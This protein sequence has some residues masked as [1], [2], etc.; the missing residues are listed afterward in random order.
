MPELTNSHKPMT[1]PIRCSFC[2][3]IP[4]Q[5][6]VQPSLRGTL[7]NQVFVRGLNH[8]DFTWDFDLQLQTI[9]NDQNRSSPT[10]S[11]D[12]QCSPNHARIVRFRKNDSFRAG[13]ASQL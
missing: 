4:L 8:F 7:F 1:S 3:V 2:I 5:R 6:F 11:I 9:V 13:L 12:F 10:S